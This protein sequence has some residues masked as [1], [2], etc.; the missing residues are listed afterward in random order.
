MLQSPFR[1]GAAL[2]VAF[3]VAPPAGAQQAPPEAAPA[4]VSSP[5]AIIHALYDV[6][7]GPMG[8]DRDQQRWHSLFAPGA[9]LIPTGRNPDTGQIG[10]NVIT[11]EEYWERS[12]ENLKRI[13]FR[14]NEIGRTSVAFG[15][16]MHAFSSYE[17]FREDQ[18]DPDTYFDRGINSI[19]LLNDGERWWIVSVYWDRERDDNPIPAKYIGT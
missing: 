14:E 9:R 16:I 6:I 19:Q 13:G 3:A 1:L 10:A 11:P 8:E 2:A 7:S 17:S 18:G 4:D 15:H 5:D 12:S